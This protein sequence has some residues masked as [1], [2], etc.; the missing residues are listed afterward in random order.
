MGNNNCCNSLPEDPG[1]DAQTFFRKGANYSYLAGIKQNTGEDLGEGP[2]IGT[3]EK[4]REAQKTPM[5]VGFVVPLTTGIPIIQ[6][7]NP[8]GKGAEEE[9]SGQ[10]R[11]PQC[12]QTLKQANLN[13]DYYKN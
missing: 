3:Q 6:H 10:G 7:P 8:I 12:D 4:I 5:A 1:K 9:R 13:T 2:L 11:L